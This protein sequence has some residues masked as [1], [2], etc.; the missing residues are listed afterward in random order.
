MPEKPL[1]D[2]VMHQA[3]AQQKLPQQQPA[4]VPTLHPDPVQHQAG[5]VP[6]MQQPQ[7][8]SQEQPQGLRAVAIQPVQPLGSTGLA[9]SLQPRIATPHSAAPGLK[10]SQ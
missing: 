9:P 10:V 4:D 8:T 1:P 6:Q 7:T 2:V 3:S 5:V